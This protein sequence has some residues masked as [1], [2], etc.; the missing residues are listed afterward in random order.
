MY[1]CSSILFS[2]VLSSLL[3]L[4][5]FVIHCSL[6]SRIYIIMYPTR[7]R[8]IF[9]SEVHS[10]LL[11]LL[12]FVFHRLYLIMYLSVFV[13]DM[14]NTSIMHIAIIVFQVGRGGGILD[15]RQNLS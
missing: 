2:E 12:P 6:D 5:P 7:C 4:V 1:I 10:S 14:P 9:F 13:G 11:R 8:S 15:K 3:K